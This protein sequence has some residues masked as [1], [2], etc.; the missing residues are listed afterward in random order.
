MSKSAI[1]RKVSAT[2]EAMLDVLCDGQWHDKQEII[3][4]GAQACIADDRAAAIKKGKALRK[5][6][7]LT[8]DDF[9]VIGGRSIANNN[10]TIACRSKRLTSSADNTRV[11]MYKRTAQEWRR[12]RSK[13]MTDLHAATKTTKGN[14]GD[15]PN[16]YRQLFGEE[17]TF[18]GWLEF[19]AW[20]LAPLESRDIAYVRPNGTLDVHALQD[21]F[22]TYRVKVEPDGLVTVS[23][24]TGAPVKENVND[25]LE[26]NNVHH[27]GVRDAHDVR[28]RNINDLPPEFLDALA[29]CYTRYALGRAYER[30]AGSLQRL[31]GSPEDISGEVGLWVMECI[32]DFNPEHGV[33]FGAWLTRRIRN[34]VMDL[35]RASYGR[36]AADA[37]MRRARAIEAFEAEHG[38]APT[39]EE[40]RIALGYSEK[41]MRRK[42]RD[43]AQLRGLR[44][45]GTLDTG[46][47]EADVPVADLSSDP[48]GESAAFEMG[49]E[50]SRALLASTGHWDSENGKP[51]AEQAVG[52]LITYLTVW[53]EWTKG[54]LTDVSDTPNRTL[55]DQLQQVET[56]MAKQL[57]HLANDRASKPRA[58]GDTVC[59]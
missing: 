29:K 16:Q 12:R 45:T 3:N 35:N 39:R 7:G 51:V 28:R 22:P 32:A 57:Q 58:I 48:E 17:Q 1:R 27:E 4:L 19:D 23:A 24:P 15:T 59:V 31:L 26:D 30:H 21:A 18:G 11:R 44:S 42:E 33:P 41:E 34:Q 36:T 20:S 13:E 56:E 43:L 37:E 52:F 50:V 5:G 25:W 8:D 54:D 14:A 2:T 6:K 9:A 38:R 47:D 49:Q 46:P 53:D 10:I 40:L 55:H